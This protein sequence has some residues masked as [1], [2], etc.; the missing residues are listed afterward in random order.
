MVHTIN[1]YRQYRLNPYEPKTIKHII[2]KKSL[3]N[4]KDF[5]H[6]M[7]KEIY[8]QIHTLNHHNIDTNDL[9]NLKL[10]NIKNIV[11]GACGS[12][13]YAGCYGKLVL[14]EITGIP[15]QVEIASEYIYRETPT[16]PNTLYVFI[17]QSGETTD[18]IAMMRK[19]K[20]I[21]PNSLLLA[22]CNV[23]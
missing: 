17:S 1:Y 23:N 21:E 11:I 13:Y 15:V 8:E 7:L 14:E 19:I 20:Q 9:K 12:S 4:K 10:E 2:E 22:L 3:V 16:I 5:E 6:F 18:T